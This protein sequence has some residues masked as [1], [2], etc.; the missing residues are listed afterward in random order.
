MCV[1][2]LDQFIAG[3]TQE[4]VL[5]VTCGSAEFDVSTDLSVVS[6][7]HVSVSVA[8]GASLT[9]GAVAAYNCVEI[10]VTVCMNISSELRTQVTQVSLLSSLS[11]SDMFLG[12][13][14]CS[15]HENY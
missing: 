8:E 7:P 1:C 13:K 2:L 5:R 15:C 12:Y 3:I 10:P 4:A 11:I 6:Q 14:N 9:I